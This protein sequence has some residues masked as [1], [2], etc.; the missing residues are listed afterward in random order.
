MNSILPNREFDDSAGSEPVPPAHLR[1]W[2]MSLHLY[3]GRASS[4]PQLP[5]STSTIGRIFP[6]WLERGP[7]FGTRPR[8][9]SPHALRAPRCAA[10]RSGPADIAVEPG[11]QAIALE[12][13]QRVGRRQAFLPA[14]TLTLN[15]N[16]VTY[17]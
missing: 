14:P 5:P 15:L 12:T 3:S 4:R 2:R 16:I 17:Q 9:R 11:D 13:E 7:S 8:G 1:Q 10:A 6:N